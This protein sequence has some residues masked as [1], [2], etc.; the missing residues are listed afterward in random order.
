MERLSVTRVARTY[1]VLQGAAGA[2]WWV[3]VFASNDV[4]RWTLGGWPHTLLVVPD[5]LLFVVASIACGC[6][7]N[8]RV[9]AVLIVWTVA[10]ICRPA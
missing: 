9:A 8:R 6:R 5:L 4:R 10:T 7:W 1:L 3:L 2:A